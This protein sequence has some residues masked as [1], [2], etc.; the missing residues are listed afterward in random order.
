M[1]KFHHSSDS[2]FDPTKSPPK[3][4]GKKKVEKIKEEDFPLLSNVIRS[5][6][7]EDTLQCILKLIG[8]EDAQSFEG[9]LEKLYESELHIHE[10]IDL[11]IHRFFLFDKN[12][13]I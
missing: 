4:K 9:S 12:F 3:N 13:Y 11:F 10:E 2:D 1:G 8:E 7:L 5:F 6:K